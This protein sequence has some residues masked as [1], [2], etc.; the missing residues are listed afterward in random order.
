MQQ[1]HDIRRALSLLWKSKRLNECSDNFSHFSNIEIPPIAAV[2]F[3][4]NNDRERSCVYDT[5]NSMSAVRNL[6]L[7]WDKILS[8]SKSGVDGWNAVFTF[9][10]ESVNHDSLLTNQSTFAVTT[11]P[12]CHAHCLF[13]GHYKKI[14]V[15]KYTG[16]GFCSNCS[17]DK[18]QITFDSHRLVN[19]RCLVVCRNQIFASSESNDIHFWNFETSLK[20]NGNTNMNVNMNNMNIDINDDISDDFHIFDTVHSYYSPFLLSDGFDL[21]QNYSHMSKFNKFNKLSKLSTNDTNFSN[22]AN[23]TLQTVQV[24]FGLVIWEKRDDRHETT[25]TILRLNDKFF[26]F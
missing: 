21:N 12:Y 7:F 2:E 18:Y 9:K 15:W 23:D 25:R 3:Y 22:D 1:G 19:V 11:D 24:I 8:S 16:I 4:A 13:S 26:F 14:R 5:M 6:V 20:N 10:I 17:C